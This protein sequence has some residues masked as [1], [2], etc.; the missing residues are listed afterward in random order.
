[1]VHFVGALKSDVFLGGT[2]KWFILWGHLRMVHFL[3]GG[4][5]NVVHFVGALKSGSFCGGT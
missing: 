4:H 1:V 3:G 2:E 5:C